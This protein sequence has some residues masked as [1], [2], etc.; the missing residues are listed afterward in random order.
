MAN[1]FD[2]KSPAFHLNDDDRCKLHEIKEYMQ[3]KRPDLALTDIGVIETL[4]AE[5]GATSFHDAVNSRY[6]E[7]VDSHAIKGGQCAR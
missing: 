7:L 1:L 2:S 6:K 5:T 4:S 3:K